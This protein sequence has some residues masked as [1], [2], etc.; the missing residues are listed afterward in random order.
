LLYALLP[1]V[2]PHSGRM[3]TPAAMVDFFDRILPDF[4]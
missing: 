1:G 4:T 2:W 3:T